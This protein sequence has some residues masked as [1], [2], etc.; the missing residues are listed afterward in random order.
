MDCAASEVG[1]KT[2]QAR[3]KKNEGSNIKAHWIPCNDCDDFWFK[4]Q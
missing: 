4:L 1:L 2:P 3:R